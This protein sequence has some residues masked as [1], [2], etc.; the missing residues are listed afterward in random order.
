MDLRK[1]II[2]ERLG[3]KWEPKGTRGG[4]EKRHWRSEIIT[5]PKSHPLEKQDAYMG[6]S[7]IVKT[8]GSR[9]TWSKK[10]DSRALKKPLKQECA[11][12]LFYNARGQTPSL[13]R[14][15]TVSHD[16]GTPLHPLL[17]VE[18]DRERERKKKGAKRG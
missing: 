16:S 9:R 18:N 5:F 1:K 12:D 10:M 11:N 14:V 3:K 8:P 15:S 6:C 7:Q 2:Q 13:R 17:C 4:M